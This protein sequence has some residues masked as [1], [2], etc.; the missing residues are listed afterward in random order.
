MKMCI[1]R[2]GFAA[3]L[4]YALAACLFSACLLIGSC[5]VSQK[6]IVVGSKSSLDQT[7]LGEIIAQHLESR[8]GRKIERRLS[9]G[10]T[11][12]TYQ[13]LQNGQIGVYPEYTGTII[14]E[15][16]KEQ[17]AADPALV[18]ERARGEMRRI[19]Q[20][21]V[22]DPLG[23]S[24]EPVAIIPVSDPRAAKVATLSD[25][26]EVKN[27]WKIGVSYEFQQR[28]DGVPAI[29][30]YHLPMDAPLRAME[31]SD[32]YRMLAEGQVTMIFGAL[33]D[34]ELATGKWK[35]LADDRKLFTPQQASILVRQTV[36][37]GEPRL[38][39]ALAELSGKFSAETMRRLNAAVAVDHHLVADVAKDF[40]AGRK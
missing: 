1:R 38:R 5:G 8:L 18:L 37:D 11:M 34:S 23:F 22:L 2:G 13:A 29:T 39:G 6:P 31:A 35:T 27:G 14:T 3:L 21:V 28:Q 30:Q 40:L 20:T 4:S 33:S 17:P 7:I 10:N 16:L 25:A 32:L 24:A 9:I 26:A 15:I 19:G 36:L 12:I